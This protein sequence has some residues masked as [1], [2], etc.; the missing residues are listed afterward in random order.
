V[1]EGHSI[2]M[3][4]YV[5]KK[6]YGIAWLSGEMMLSLT[7][8]SFAEQFDDALRDLRSVERQVRGG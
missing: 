1:L 2:V 8:V 5:L 6:V 4:P 7:T 3:L